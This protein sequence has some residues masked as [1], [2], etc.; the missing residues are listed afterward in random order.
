MH[1][2]LEAKCDNSAKAGDVR[3]GSVADIMLAKA[4]VRYALES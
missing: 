1:G 2:K 3:F 4:E